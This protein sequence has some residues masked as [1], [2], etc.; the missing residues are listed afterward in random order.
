[1]TAAEVDYNL[2][3]CA[4][5]NRAGKA[6]SSD[7]TLDILSEIDL[8]RVSDRELLETIHILSDYAQLCIDLWGMSRERLRSRTEALLNPP[9]GT[10]PTLLGAASFL[11]SIGPLG[12]LIATFWV[13]YFPANSPKVAL[14]APTYWAR[15]LLGRLGSAVAFPWYL[16]RIP[17]LIHLALRLKDRYPSIGQ[18]PRK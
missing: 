17:R 11:R 8:G 2:Q 18:E 13:A 15:R 6:G 12:S 10:H 16:V 5:A 7:E 1:M 3:A 4:M 14:T 9:A